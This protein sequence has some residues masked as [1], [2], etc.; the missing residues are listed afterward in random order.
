MM[1]NDDDE[2]KTDYNNHSP[3]VKEFDRICFNFGDEDAIVITSPPSLAESKDNDDNEDNTHNQ[4]EESSS[5]SHCYYEIQEHS[6]NLANQLYYRMGRPDFVLV[7]CRGWPVAEAVATLACMRIRRPFVPVSAADQHRPGR[8]ESVVDLLLNQQQHQNQEQDQQQSHQVDDDHQTQ[9]RLAAVVVCRDDRD[10]ILSVFQHAGVHRILAL[11]AAGVLQ[12]C[13][14][15][16]DKI[17]TLVHDGDDYDYMYILFTSGTTSD[18]NSSPKAVV[19]SHRATWKRIRWF[20]QNFES[21]SRVGR[22]TKL[23]FVDGITELWCCLLD[24]NP[25]SILVCVPPIRLESYGIVTLVNDAKCTQ[26]L[27]LPSQLHQLFLATRSSLTVNEDSQEGRSSTTK[28]DSNGNCTLERVIVSGEVCTAALLEQFRREFPNTQLINLYGQTETTG[29][30]MFAI[31]SELD[32]QNA[33]VENVVTVGRPIGETCVR[34]LTHDHDGAEDDERENSD[35]LEGE[36]EIRGPYLS[37]GYLGRN[38][39]FGK[40]KIPFDVFCPGDV[41]F[42]DN[43]QWYI[44]GRSDDVKKI[45]GVLTGTSEV[46][47]AFMKTHGINGV[48][49]IPDNEN[50]FVI[51]CEESKVVDSFSRQVMIDKGIPFHLIP[52]IVIYHPI[53]RSQTG[54][55]KVDRKT[56]LKIVNDQLR[57][58]P[59]K[60]MLPT[61]KNQRSEPSLFLKTVAQVLNVNEGKLSSNLS[62]VENGGDSATSITLLYQLKRREWGNICHNLDATDI[63]SSPSLSD[64]ES[65]VSTGQRREPKRA[66]VQND[67]SP[68][69]EQSKESILMIYDRKMSTHRIVRKT[70][71]RAEHVAIQMRACVDASPLIIGDSIYAACQGGMILL[72]NNKSGRVEATRSYS[73]WMFQ[74]SVLQIESSNRI[75]AC[76]RSSE[77]KLGLVVCLSP[78][79][80]EE[81]WTIVIKD[82][83]I[84][85]D[86]L[87]YKRTVWVLSGNMVHCLD[88][89]SGQKTEEKSWILPRPCKTA[90]ILLNEKPTIGYA[91]SDWEGGIMVFDARSGQVSICVDFEIGPV[92][93]N[94]TII[95]GSSTVIISDTYGSIHCF[96]SDELKLVSS[97]QLASTTLSGATPLL[98]TKKPTYIVGSYDGR[99]FCLQHQIYDDDDDRPGKSSEMFKV[100]EYNCQSSV[101]TQPLCVDDGKY[102][103]VCTTSGDVN[104]LLT[105][106]DTVRAPSLSYRYMIEGEIWSQP[107]RQILDDLIVFGARDS[108]LH[109]LKTSNV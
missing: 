105:S 22:R 74:A 64:L 38:I 37:H 55:A 23:T 44:R 61:D 28:N 75:L 35:R 82:G 78:D 25:N 13:L 4:Q 100:W 15:V 84:I 33:V 70:S 109:L 104:V 99:L 53:P 14:N 6:K 21:S 51:I 17:P 66:R 32:T 1:D 24:P 39:V 18:G 88:I 43:G 10:P 3:I 9:I 12:D 68:I 77:G 45:N 2:F 95:P 19:G 20:L 54:A 59:S 90:P 94:P 96:D 41:G 106:E 69:P 8:M 30:C 60:G 98:N 87:I 89:D 47:A 49:V 102:I 79:L 101:Y 73:G 81:I 91:S 36:L 80:R 62:F 86:P 103:V 57:Q 16:P 56:C 31:L 5:S 92:H 76:A 83:P 97:L 7:D 48:A 85:S 93:K 26:L 107:R 58:A 71:S 63:M 108:N 67:Q 46:E 40:K 27:L 29:D 34:V 11:D 52:R 42:N 72:Y 50:F 65:L